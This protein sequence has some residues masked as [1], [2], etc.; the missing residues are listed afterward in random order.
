MA[1]WH[2]LHLTSSIR[3]DVLAGL[4]HRLESS[5]KP[6]ELVV[7]VAYNAFCITRHVAPIFLTQLIDICK[8]YY[9]F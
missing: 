5:F 9:V 8:E 7:S 4:A 6:T 3:T 1:G 2:N